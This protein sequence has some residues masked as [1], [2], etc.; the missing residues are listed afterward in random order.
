MDFVIPRV[1]PS[2]PRK[3]MTKYGVDLL[4]ATIL[5]R[6]GLLE[7]DE[8]RYYLDP[9][10]N[11]LPSPFFFE[12]MESVVERINN[13]KTEGEKVVIFGDRDADGITSTTLLYTELKEMGI[14]V[15]YRVPEKDEP[16]GLTKDVCD[17]FIEKDITLV[18]TVDCGISCNSEIEY[19]SQNYIDTVVLDHHLAGDNLPPAVAIIDPKVPGSGYP[20][21]DL[22]GCGVVAKVIWALRF[23]QTDLYNSEFILLHAEAGPG[24]DTSTII[25]ALRL[26]NLMEIDYLVEEIP[27]KSLE[28]TSSRMFKFLSVN[29]P[30]LVLDQEIEHTLLA[31]AFGSKC[32]IYLTDVREEVEKVIPA[33]K[34]KS[35]LLLSHESR[36]AKYSKY[37]IE[38]ETLRSLFTSYCLY[39]HPNLTRDYEKILDLVAIGTV[40][41]LMPIKGENRI[42]VKRGLKVL[43]EAPRESLVPLMSNLKLLSK[44]V[45]TVELGW[46]LCPVINASGR[47]GCPSVAIEMLISKDRLQI[48]DLATQLVQLNKQRKRMGDEAWDKVKNS[49]KKSCESFG[50]KFALIDNCNIARGLTGSIAARVLKEYSVPGAIVLSEEIDGRISGS[51]RSRESLPSRTF[52]SCLS[53]FFTDFGGHKC[54]GGFSMEATKLEEFKKQLDEQVL[55][56]DED[57]VEEA[58]VVDAVIPPQYMNPNLIK[59]VELFEPYGEQN[60]PLQFLMESAEIEN[61]VKVGSDSEK[62][63]IK[64]QIKYGEFSWIAMYWGGGQKGKIE[65]GDKAKIIFRLARN[66]WNGQANLVLTILDMEKL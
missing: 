31:Q 59:I 42:L 8:I 35:L 64:L 1:D 36:M 25:H 24:E 29:L 40:A 66:Y 44:P 9:S 49:A 37:D 51:M 2:V 22:A 53:S 23:S 60:G 41:D 33:I 3:L 12:D 4:S 21:A 57:S 34:G 13:A 17:E 48:E 56:L 50:S 46:Y 65:V 47:L 39:K 15:S 26:Y 18:I 63:N 5:A 55:L 28:L 14:D 43:S 27:N 6:R 10:L 20:F 30:I 32:D 52:L 45:T 11:N 38:I 61:C 19:L 62:G 7:G 16:Y 58:R 54:A